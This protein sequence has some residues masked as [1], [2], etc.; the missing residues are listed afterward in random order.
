M[1][2]AQQDVSAFLEHLRTPDDVNAFL[3]R[4]RRVVSPGGRIA[5]MGP[6]IRYCEDSYW[7]FADHW[8]PFTEKAIEEHLY[9]AGFQA[10]AVHPRYLPFSFT[11]RLPASPRLTSTYLKTKVAWRLL[12]KQFFLI[13]R[14]VPVTRGG[15]FP[16]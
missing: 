15:S 14:K 3:L 2:A 10:T 4:M 7:D 9:T 16:E 8:L 5:I 6:N 12:G 13:A 1:T 11:G